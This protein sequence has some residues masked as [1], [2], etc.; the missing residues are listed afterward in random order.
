MTTTGG[1]S[2]TEARGGTRPLAIGGDDM[3]RHHG[4]STCSA[5]VNGFCTNGFPTSPGCR[6]GTGKKPYGATACTD[7]VWA[8]RLYQE[9][10]QPSWEQV[11]RARALSLQQ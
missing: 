3:A 1:K 8:W 5:L 7:E 10:G 9:T 6:F 11:E 4:A 2:N